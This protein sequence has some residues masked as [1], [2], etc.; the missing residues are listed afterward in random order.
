MTQVGAR[1]TF[2][3]LDRVLG[4]LIA[5]HDVSALEGRR[6]VLLF[7]AELAETVLLAEALHHGVAQL[8]FLA[9]T[10]IQ[11]AEGTTNEV[12]AGESEVFPRLDMANEA[13]ISAG[14]FL[15]ESLLEQLLWLVIEPEDLGRD[16][17][18]VHR[19]VEALPVEILLVVMVLII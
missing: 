14:L 5:H 2:L 16:A 17:F 6:D 11:F 1:R 4:T 19:F 15:G 10:D 9:E 8:A 3:S 12:F 7:V 18:I 13:K